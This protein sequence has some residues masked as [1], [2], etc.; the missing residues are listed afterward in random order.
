MTGL[1]FNLLHLFLARIDATADAT[2]RADVFLGAILERGRA[3]TRGDAL[4]VHDL[5]GLSAMGAT[6]AETM[7]IWLAKARRL[8]AQEVMVA[9]P[10]PDIS[11]L[12]LDEAST[13]V[14]L[15][16]QDDRAK[17]AARRVMDASALG[18]A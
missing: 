8:A 4:Q 18:M 13:A 12:D 10:T 2:D 16:S 11:Q 7:E 17:A 3:T 5:F 9:A 14:L 1:P 15:L 6:V